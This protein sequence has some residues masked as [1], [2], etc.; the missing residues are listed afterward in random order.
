MAVFLPKDV[1]RNCGT[2]IDEYRSELFKTK[3]LPGIR[4]FPRVRQLFERILHDGYRIAL[5]SSAKEEELQEY[6]RR[7]GVSDLLDAETSSDDADWSK[8]HPDIFRDQQSEA[9][10]RTSPYRWRYALRRRGGTARRSKSHWSVMRR[11]FGSLAPRIG[12][13]GDLPGRCGSAR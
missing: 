12:L 2:R 5:A 4:P 13:R 8:P 1:V 10:S 3:L 9:R 6:K 7:A 11:V